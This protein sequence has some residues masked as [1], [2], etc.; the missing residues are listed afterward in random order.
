MAYATISDFEAYMHWTPGTVTDT[1]ETER[2]IDRASELIDNY[3]LGR[4]E[5]DN[6]DHIAAANK[7]T[8]AQIE[9]WLEQGEGDDMKRPIKQYSASKISVTFVDGLPTRLAA[10]A[11]QALLQSGLLYCGVSAARGGTIPW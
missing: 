7:A 10:R 9:Y 1:A 4:I 6:P 8:C 11:R 2:L 3:T 5:D